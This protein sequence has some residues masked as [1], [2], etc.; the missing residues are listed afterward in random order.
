MIT[1]KFILMFI[2]AILP[3]LF[4]TH[5]KGKSNLATTVATWL[6]WM[7]K[8]AQKAARTVR[9]IYEGMKRS[10]SFRKF[11]RMMLIITLLVYTWTEF[12]TTEEY[13]EK[14]SSLAVG[15]SS[16]NACAERIIYL[17]MI[18]DQYT[19]AACLLLTLSLF[20]DR[21]SDR[22]LTEIHS[23][24][25]LQGLM[26][27]FILM[28]TA[29]SAMQEQTHFFILAEVIYII[30]AASWAYPDKVGRSDPKGRKPIP[31]DQKESQDREYRKAA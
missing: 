6:P 24:K 12:Q 9:W 17:N 2:L 29:M 4:T 22:L 26:A 11:F 14:I 8:A 5:V 31:A 28:I 27:V 16:G 10:D 30:L 1:F 3:F 13:Q 21:W 19:L 18:P 25:K 20:L 15:D 7:K 23:A